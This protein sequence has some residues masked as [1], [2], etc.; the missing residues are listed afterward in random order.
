[1]Q[2]AAARVATTFAVVLNWRSDELTV[3]CVDGLSR[4]I[5]RSRVIVVDNETRHALDHT[6]PMLDGVL[7]LEQKENRGFAAGVNVGISSAL[8]DQRC[9]YVLLINNDVHLDEASLNALFCDEAWPPG[10]GLVA[11][12][13]RNPDGSV[14]T[15]G[16]RVSPWTM[17]VVDLTSP[18]ASETD[19]VTGACVLVR[20]E[21]F[22]QIGLFDERFFMYWEDAELGARAASSGFRSHVIADAVALHTRS[23]SHSA[24][25]RARI[26]RYQAIGTVV[27]ARERGGAARVGAVLRITARLLKRALSG[28]L[29][30]IGSILTGARVG[31]RLNQPAYLD[32][33]V[34][35]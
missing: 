14:Q 21:V 5:D 26:D 32:P 4:L 7:V 3:R 33:A 12:V 31:L 15:A 17:A 35:R 16:C 20:R 2:G 10:V 22:E 8:A 13:L 18:D 28:D 19:F 11:P 24:A 29:A 27:Y 23:A 6:S 25:G 1:M 30:C 34:T 9:G